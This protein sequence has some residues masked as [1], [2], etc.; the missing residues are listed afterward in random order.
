[1]T[2]HQLSIFL[3]NKSG[4]LLQVFNLLKEANISL[5]ASN[6]ADTV[7][8]GICRFICNDSQKAYKVLRDAGMAVNLTEV[9]ALEIENTAGE[10]AK[11]ISLLSAEGIN[12]PYLYSFLLA[13]KGV[14]IFRTDNPERTKEV[15]KDN[16]LRFITEGQIATM[17]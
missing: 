14:L 10:A 6:L 9:F 12:I 4:T 8:Y 11:A 15:I 2:I 1:M 5:V 16:K 7:E 13:G 3:E 17:M